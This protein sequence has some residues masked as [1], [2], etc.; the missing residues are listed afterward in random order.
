M[1]ET[2]RKLLLRRPA[3]LMLVRYYTPYISLMRFRHPLDSY[4]A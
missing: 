4:M 1:S 3:R 2:G